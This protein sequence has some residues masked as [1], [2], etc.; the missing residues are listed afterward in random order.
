MSALNKTGGTEGKCR[1]G[2]VHPPGARV[3]SALSSR[4]SAMPIPRGRG[5]SRR[6]EEIGGDQCICGRRKQNAQ[7][8]ADLVLLAP[9]RRADFPLAYRARRGVRPPTGHTGEDRSSQPL[10]SSPGLAIPPASSGAASPPPPTTAPEEW[11][12]DA[13]LLHPHDL[14]REVVGW[15]EPPSAPP[16]PVPMTVVLHV[17]LPEPVQDSFRSS[18]HS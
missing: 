2:A 8:A 5:L 4:V 15:H 11:P 18:G 7:R 12:I 17:H 9:R 16:P 1:P 3:P 6:R 14:A 10:G 13:K